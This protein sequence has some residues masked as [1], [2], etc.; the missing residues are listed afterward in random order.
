VVKLFTNS[1]GTVSGYMLAH[2]R[3]FFTLLLSLNL[4]QGG[5]N[6]SLLHITTGV[7]S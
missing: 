1:V 7:R 5:D 4:F 6:V 2:L 3:E